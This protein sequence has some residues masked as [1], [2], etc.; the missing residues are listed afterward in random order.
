MNRWLIVLAL[1]V[2]FV[3]IGLAMRRGWLRRARTQEATLPPF[4]RPPASSNTVELLPVTTGLYVG[5]TYAGRWHD[6]V[7]TGDIGHRAAARGHLSTEGLLL[8][9]QGANPLW[10]PATSLIETRVDT[11]L[12]GKVIPGR[13]MLVI[14]WQLEDVWLD[15]GFRPDGGGIQERWLRVLTELAEAEQSA[16]PAQ[17]EQT[18]QEA[19]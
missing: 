19:T 14:R 16:P 1:L 3:L 11:K 13:G 7:V 4:P 9:R 15:T 17:D 6:R 8:E 10:I 18:G 12:A 5:T 2:V